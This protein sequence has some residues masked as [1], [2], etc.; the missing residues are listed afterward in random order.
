MDFRLSVFY[1]DSSTKKV[2]V[3]KNQFKYDDDMK[4]TDIVRFLQRLYPNHYIEFV[5]L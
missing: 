4:L 5:A 1:L 2:E 3:Y